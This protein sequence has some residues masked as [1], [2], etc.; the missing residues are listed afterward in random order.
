MPNLKSPEDRRS[1]NVTIRLKTEEL[2][3]L[4]NEAE[5]RQCTR[6]DVIRDFINDSNFAQDARNE[7]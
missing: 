2:E 1:K 6:T 4:D 3:I 7:P 5:I